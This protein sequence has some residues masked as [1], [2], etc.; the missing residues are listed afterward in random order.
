MVVASCQVCVVGQ[1]CRGAGVPTLE[2]DER[3]VWRINGYLGASI[4]CQ[5]V[6]TNL[7]L[8]Q[9]Y[10]FEG[11][12]GLRISFERKRKEVWLT[13]IGTIS[14]TMSGGRFQGP[15]GIGRIDLAM[16]DGRIEELRTRQVDVVREAII[17]A[18]EVARADELSRAK[19]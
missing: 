12:T 1:G 2:T 14:S 6:L 8:I 9:A 11:W 17:D 5:L 3:I 4:D 7:R 18:V 10:P 13:D 19:G 16:K 15:L